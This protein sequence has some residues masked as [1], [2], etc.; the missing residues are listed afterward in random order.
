MIRPVQT[1]PTAHL[2]GPMRAMCCLGPHHPAP[3]PAR[4]FPPSFS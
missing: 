4:P 2:R 1:A 3:V